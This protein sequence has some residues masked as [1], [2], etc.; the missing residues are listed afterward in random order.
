MFSDDEDSA[1]SNKEEQKPSSSRDADYLLR[2]DSS[3]HN[4]TQGELNNPIR[5]LEL[6]KKIRQNFWHQ[7]YKSGIYYT[8]L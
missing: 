8:T 4:I 2:T 1:S 6:Q 5:D 7:V 3:N